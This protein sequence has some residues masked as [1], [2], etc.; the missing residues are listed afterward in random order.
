[1]GRLYSR[2]P[3]LVEVFGRNPDVDAAVDIVDSD[4]D[5][6]GFPVS[7][8]ELL[9]LVS[10]SAQDGPAGSGC[11][12]V[13]ITG[14]GYS[15]DIQTEDVALNGATPVDSLKTWRRVF[16]VV[17]L[18]G[19]LNA[20]IITVTHKT[21]T[22]NIFAKIQVGYNRSAC[23]VYTIPRG[24]VGYLKSVYTQIQGTG[25]NDLDGVIWAREFGAAPNLIMPYSMTKP[26]E[27][28]RS[29]LDHGVRF[30]ELTDIKLRVTRIATGNAE[31]T[32]QMDI[33]VQ[34]VD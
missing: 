26:E 14:L 21:T 13:R 17:G 15:W 12:T 33:E 23:A 5:Y 28:H 10:G 30:P 1:M 4:E 22:T 11:K 18:T 6:S 29:L 19:A 20:G 7:A 3:Y 8:C 24:C 34:A 27:F 9:T 25:N 31:V 32:A 2:Q 16:S